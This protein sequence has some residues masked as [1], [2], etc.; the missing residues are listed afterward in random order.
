MGQGQHA[1]DR[2]IAGESVCVIPGSYAG[3]APMDNSG[4]AN[5]P[6]VFMFVGGALSITS[7]CSENNLDGINV[8]DVSWVV[9]EGFTLI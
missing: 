8:E 7:P 1:A 6:I 4:A 5:A 3:F 2:A 9:I